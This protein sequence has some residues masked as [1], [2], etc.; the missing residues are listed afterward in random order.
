[1][2]ILA[3]LTSTG[4]YQHIE[5]RKAAGTLS[6]LAAEDGSV[7]CVFVCCDLRYQ[8][9]NEYFAKLADDCFP[10]IHNKDLTDVDLYRYDSAWE[11]EVDKTLKQ[12]Y[13]FRPETPR[14]LSLES[15]SDSDSGFGSDSEADLLPSLKPK[16]LVLDFRTP[17]DFQ[18]NHLP[19]AI[20]ISLKSLSLDT[21]NPFADSDTLAAQWRELEALF[22]GD[23]LKRKNRSTGFEGRN[24]FAKTDQNT[25][26]T[27]VC[28][29]GDTARIGTSVLRNQGIA[30]SNIR[31]GMDAVLAAYPDLDFSGIVAT[32]KGSQNLQSPNETF[33][34]SG[35]KPFY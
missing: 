14:R 11:Q 2:G 33:S 4:L 3:R 12:I 26:V 23:A 34:S 1:M 13:E 9:I 24:I 20:N 35:V 8:Y 31:G 16:N 7:H 25:I 18:Q 5:K 32:V 21:P 17:S 29:D 22:G 15:N 30:A 19:D 27:L 10:A 28:Y 6:E